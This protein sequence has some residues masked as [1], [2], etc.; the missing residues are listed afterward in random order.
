MVAQLSVSDIL[1]KPINL[2]ILREKK[3]MRAAQHILPSPTVV[4]VL[5]ARQCQE[6]SGAACDWTLQDSWHSFKRNQ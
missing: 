5:V 3:F 6:Q 2:K 4:K 1:E